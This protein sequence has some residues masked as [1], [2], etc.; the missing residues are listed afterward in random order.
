MFKRNQ[1]A[2]TVHMLTK[3][4]VF[5]NHATRQALGFQNPRYLKKAQQLK[6]TLY[7]GSVIGK[8]E[9]IVMLD[10]KNTLMHAEESRSKMIEKQNDPQMIEKKVI[11]KPID[12]AILNQLS[13]DFNTRRSNVEI[14]SLMY[15]FF[16]VDQMPLP[17]IVTYAWTMATTIDQQVA[18]GESLVPS[19]AF[20][21]IAD[22]PEIYMQEFWATAKLHHNSIRFK[23]DTKKSSL[24]LEAFREMLHISLRIPSQSFAELP[25][26]EEILDFLRVAES[27]CV[28]I[29]NTFSRPDLQFAICMCARYQ[30]RSTK[31]HVHSVKRI[32]RYLRR[33]V[34]R[35]ADHAGC[36]DT[37]RSTSGSVQ[38]L[39]ERLISWSSKR[40]KS[41]VIS[42]T[43]AEYIDL[44]GCCDKLL[45]MRSQILDY[46]LR[47]NKIP[48]YHFIKEQVENGVIKLYFINTEYRLA[49]LFT[50]A[51]GRERIEFLINKL[52][53]RIFTPETLKQ[54]MNEEDE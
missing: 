47:F 31:K 50:K 13:T 1:S 16:F 10:F 38:F 17:I 25:F 21:V 37:C 23:I 46:G 14:S 6:P 26:E 39:G 5:Y 36:Q 20:Q 2:Q 7:D 44:S 35:D 34:H 48:I 8:S 28:M 30:A 18:L 22:V 51:L 52:G 3:P 45:W 19:T 4:Q 53:M 24:D 12:Y 9:V 43:E 42:S 40:Q 29:S 54:L 33:T 49:D 15:M 27:A 41:A 11:T 32:F